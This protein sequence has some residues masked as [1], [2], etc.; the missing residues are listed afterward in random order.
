MS[1]TRVSKRGNNEPIFLSILPHTWRMIHVVK[2]FN[3]MFVLSLSQSSSALALS[4]QQDVDVHDNFFADN[5]HFHFGASPKS[6]F[7]HNPFFLMLPNDFD[8]FDA[9]GD[10]GNF[11]QVHQIV[12]TIQTPIAFQKI[13]GS[14]QSSAATVASTTRWR[15]SR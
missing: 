9:S 11:L 3:S 13:E 4:P 14:V 2:L 6:I 7:M 10:N 8:D 12:Q 5:S 1:A 15:A